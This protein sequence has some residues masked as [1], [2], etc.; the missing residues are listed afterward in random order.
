MSEK[1][2]AFIF[3][4]FV[5]EYADDPVHHLSGFAE[6]FHK[7][8]HQ[9]AGLVSRDLANFNFRT[10][11]FLEDE[12]KTQFI[13]YIYSC[14]LSSYLKDKGITSD[15]CAGYSMGIYAALFHAEV[16]SFRDGL[17][18]ISRAFR[19]IQ[20]VTRCAPFS[21]GTIIGLNREDVLQI[22]KQTGNHVEIT[23]QNSI[24]SFV[25]GGPEE[26]INKT[27]EMAKSEGALSTR[28]IPVSDPYHT[29]YINPP[30]A[31]HRMIMN[32][33]HFNDP[34]I[35]VV[36]LIDRKIIRDEQSLHDEVIRNL[37]TPMNWYKTQ[38]FLQEK[39]VTVFIE[40]GA[41][42]GLSK[43][44][45]FIEGDAVF[46]SPDSNSFLMELEKIVGGK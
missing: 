7:S 12:L 31:D 44:S 35:P 6:Y 39:G 15:Y 32:G 8:L 1:S 3:P 10:N 5:S 45:R 34:A 29:T 14:A 36:S 20:S 38:L 9:A 13:T 27:L 4:A 2:L 25:L 46:L 43:N 28:V 40:C 19:S 24:C 33:M 16:V 30:G 41:G 42:K 37:Y 23:N 21:M 22:L 26:D 18:L 11:T 17:E